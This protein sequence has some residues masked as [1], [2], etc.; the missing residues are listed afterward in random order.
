MSSSP[1]PAQSAGTTLDTLPEVPV[2]LL[3]LSAE[4]LITAGNR[5]AL[6]VLGCSAEQLAGAPAAQ[7]WGLDPAVLGTEGVWVAPGDD[8][9]RR[10]RYQREA[11]AGGWLLSLPHVETAA[12]L[13]DARALSTTTTATPMAVSTPMQPLVQ[14]LAQAAADRQ[15]L[16]QAGQALAACELTPPMMPADVEGEVGGKLRA[17]FGNLAE[18]IR[19]AV[20]LSVQIASQV[21]HLVAENDELAR[22]TQAQGEALEE[23]MEATRRLTERLQGVGEELRQ[24]MDVAASADERARQGREAAS[25][26]NAAMLE[27]E[28]RAA[29]ASEV[30]EVI[31]SVAFQTNI[32]SINASIEAAHAGPAGKGFAV[33]AGEIRRLAER[34]ASG[35]R[36]VRV[37][38]DETSAAVGEG[39]QSARRT[40]EVL[41]GIGA[42]MGRAS[43]A[44]ATVA[45]RLGAQGG[46]I[47]AIES[48]VDA[49]VALGRS[50]L[51]HAEQVARRSEALGAGTETLR[52]CVGL[53]RLPEDPMREPRHATVRALAEEAARRI[54]MA[55]QQA[56]DQH[57]IEPA[58]L[59]G[60][61]YTPIPGTSPEKYTSGFDRLCDQVLPVF[62]EPVLDAQPWIVFAICANPDGYVPTHN[63][64]F[65]QPLT[66]DPAVDLVG[67][68]TKRI[69]TD[70]VGRSVGAHN[71]PYRLQVYRRDTGQIMFDLS[72]PVM[73]GRRHW[74]G[75]RVGYT[76]E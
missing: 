46:E 2:A 72:V 19:Q 38:I 27:V 40:E 6:D 37:I 65:T 9:A 45:E 3:R 36:D 18:A 12:L 20:A 26:L 75:F 30:I 24:V 4:G 62:Q 67:N 1:P 73:V 69:F 23:V 25:G 34:A 39:A 35:A 63:L 31:D 10:V 17:G 8:P 43:G 7:L 5:M 13:R 22:Q 28:R 48:S 52:D 61:D 47:R 55:L 70:R 66:G 49:V 33:V 64:R 42:L 57:R 44:M 58:A 53:F 14:R 59:F 32:L 68:R 54:G 29:R 51:E 21:P 71:D 76:L 60:R 41:E 74:G 16:L 15:L 50:N 11:Q 56:L